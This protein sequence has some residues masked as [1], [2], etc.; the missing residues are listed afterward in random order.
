VG[1]FPAR[2]NDG[3]MS[4][5]VLA[6]AA[7]VPMH[8]GALHPVERLVVLAIAFGPF[9]VLGIVVLIGRRSAIAAERA[10]RA[11]LDEQEQQSG[12]PADK[13]GRRPG[14]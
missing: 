1:A 14:A 6:W 7:V 13:T 10:E 3:V 8:L 2:H 4:E 11:E 9:V 12:G 5:L